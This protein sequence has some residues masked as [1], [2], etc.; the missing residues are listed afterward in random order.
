[1]NDEHIE[2]LIADVVRLECQL[3]EAQ[4]WETRATRLERRIAD[5]GMELDEARGK[6]AELERLTYDLHRRSGHPD[7]ACLRCQFYDALRGTKEGK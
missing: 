5:L 2:H 1:M 6:L 3:A 7:P 4:D